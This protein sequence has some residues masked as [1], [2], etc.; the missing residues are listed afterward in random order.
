MVFL[1]VPYLFLVMGITG[2]MT[3]PFYFFNK[4]LVK[5][6]KPRK[7]GGNL[8]LYF[9]LVLLSAFV[10]ITAGIYLIVKAAKAWQ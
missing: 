3:I 8:L 10:Y 4:Y 5:L 7:S 6:T 2:V 1:V 9:F